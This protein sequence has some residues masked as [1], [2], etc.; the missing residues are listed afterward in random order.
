MYRF[1]NIVDFMAEDFQITIYNEKF[2]ECK[3]LK[4]K[5]V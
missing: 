5:Y 2:A 1:R 3:E 4:Q